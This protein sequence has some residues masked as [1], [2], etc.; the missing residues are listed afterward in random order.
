VS[1]PQFD[2]GHLEISSSAIAEGESAGT[3]LTSVTASNVVDQVDG[4]RLRGPRFPELRAAAPVILP[5]LLLCDFGHL[6][7]EI[8]RLEGAGVQA[9]HLD[10]M[11]GHFVPN[12]TYGPL[13]VEAT[14]KCSSLPIEVHLMISDP[15]KYARDFHD[16]GA[17]HLTFHVEAVAD[18]RP[19]LDQIHDLDCTAGLAINPPTPLSAIEA[20]V[21]RFDSILVMS[22]MP[23]F[24]GQK[25][26]PSALGKLKQL[27][28]RSG[29]GGPLRGIDG[30]IH[31]STIGEAAAAG[32]ELF[33]VGSAIFHPGSDYGQSLS[34][35]TELGRGGARRSVER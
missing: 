11:D 4:C 18:P 24:G 23:G 17:D 32:A 13:I 16:A 9:W 30:G 2:F 12:L 35:L 29:G 33:A 8:A 7:D 34:E 5:S 3:R 21:D 19:V 31:D 6:A 26:D 28:D 15:A 27:R 14:R 1:R 22:V 20:I 25:F 10:V